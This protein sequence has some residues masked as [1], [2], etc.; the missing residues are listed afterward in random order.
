MYHLRSSLQHNQQHRYGTTSLLFFTHHHHHH[1]HGPTNTA[2]YTNAQ[3]EKAPLPEYNPIPTC[4]VPIVPSF[5]A[6]DGVARDGD[7]RLVF[8]DHP[9]F[10]PNLTPR[11]VIQAGSFGGYV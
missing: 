1:H 8:P 2:L 9:E 11:Q 6:N 4:K 5:D 3:Q 7:G 10:R